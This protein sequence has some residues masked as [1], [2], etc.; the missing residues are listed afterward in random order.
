MKYPYP[1]RQ[2]IGAAIMALAL[3]LP[4]HLA[5]ADSGFWSNPA[6][7]SWTNSA[8]WI[9]NIMAE[10]TDSVA[11]L[12][13]VNLEADR[14]VTLDGART[15]GHLV[16]GDA[17]PDHNWSLE[18]GT[19][20]PLTLTVGSGSPTVTVYNQAATVGVVL[21]GSQGL[22][23]LGNGTLVLTGANTYSGTTLIEA[24]SLTFSDQ[25]ASTGTGGSSLQVGGASGNGVLNLNSSA[26]SAFATGKSSLLMYVGGNAA[27]GNTGAGVINQT[28]GTINLGNVNYLTLGVTGR[29]TYGAYNLA[30][31]TLNLNDGAGFRLGFGGIG[32]FVQSGGNFNCGRWFAIGCGQATGKGVATF[33]GGT[34]TILPTYQM[35]LVDIANSTGVVNLGTEAGGTA[36]VTHLNTTGVSVQKSAGGNGTLNL[37]R[38]TLRLGGPIYRNNSSGGS[39]VLNLNGGTLQAGRD[40]ILLIKSGLSRV[41]VYNG[42]VVF[43]TQGYSSSNSVALTT[44]EGNGIYPAGGTLA[45]GANGGAGYIGA[46]DVTITTSGAG[47]NAMAIATIVGGVVTNVI[48]TCPG[49]NYLPEDTLTFSFIG[50]G[51]SWWSASPYDYTLTAGDL[52]ANSQGGLAKT[53]TGALTLASP[54]TYAGKTVVNDGTLQVTTDGALGTGDVEV[55][56]GAILI[57]E[58]GINSGYIDTSATLM[59][60]SNAA[61]SL[62]FTGTNTIKG[63]SLDGGITLAAL[64]TWGA[65]GA[66]AA[67]SAPQ[68]A[69]QGIFRVRGDA[70]NAALELAAT[71][72]PS[73]LGE[74]VTLTASVTGEAGIPTGTVTFKDGTDVL[75]SAALN[76][77]GIATLATSA[78]AIGTHSLS[79]VFSGN[80]TY[81]PASSAPLTQVVSQDLTWTGEASHFWDSRSLNWHSL[82]APAAYSDGSRV[83]F[84]DSATKNTDIALTTTAF[85]SAV[86]VSNNLRSYSF[87]GP[88]GIAG[89]ASLIKL[90]TG[91]LTLSN[92]NT[93]TGETVIGQG[94]LAVRGEG[95][96]I[97]TTNGSLFVGRD[98]SKGVLEL[99]GSGILNFATTTNSLL[100]YVGGSGGPTD[101]S[102]GAINQTDGILNFGNGNYLT[103]GVT[104]TDS[105]GAYEL[106]GGTLN[107][108]DGAGMRLGFGGIGSFVQSGGNFNCGRWF[109]IGAGGATGKGV[110]TF[111]GGAATIHP[112][113]QMLLPDYANSTGVVNL[114][115][116]AGGTAIVTHLN[117]TGLSVQKSAGGNG[118]LN[119]NRGTLRLGGPIYRNNSS[120]GSAVLNLNGGTLQAGRNNILLI[121]SGLSSVTLYN[122][123]VVFDTQGYTVT[124]SAAL[125][126]A[127]GSGIYPAGG[128]LA[129]G[130]DGGTGY[131][132][133]PDVTVTTS[134]AGSNVMA[135][136]TIANGVVTQVLLTCP[137]ENYV[138]GDMVI[139]MFRGG[140]ADIPANPLYYTLQA[141]DLAG[142]GT[143]GL[144]KVGAGVL[145]LGGENSYAGPTIVSNGTLRVDGS[146]SANAIVKAGAILG[147]NGVISGTVSVEAGGAI[148]AGAGIGTLTLN[149]MPV[150]N[151]AVVAEV[152]RNGGNP[153]ADRLVVSG[154]PATYAG[155]LVLTNRGAPLQVGDTFTL[156]AASEYS[157]NFTIVS[158]TPG[159]EVSW[160]TNN[161]TVN[162]SVSVLTV[163]AT[164]PPGLSYGF[165]STTLDLAWPA[166]YL[167]WGL[168]TNAVSITADA[169]FPYPGSTSQ[170]NI[171]ITVNPGDSNVF[172]RLVS[173]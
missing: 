93:Y 167:G 111:T 116:E 81:N 165:S 108:V 115:T 16:F 160:D 104:A 171:S 99:D 63:L 152:D 158:Q 82:S 25:G 127:E 117:T 40:N 70:D 90:G 59:L 147:G 110:A 21:A 46:P 87:S 41:T 73:Q 53:G 42:G 3:A 35:L 163:A 138:V 149:A 72:S 98:N 169:W 49:E 173:P 145:T 114:G 24:G 52:A 123:G 39:A 7:G 130:A 151:G 55:R 27:A 23:L 4:S 43:D 31:G 101:T 126:K 8:N 57:L 44:A 113:Y 107:I 85:P 92:L 133:A 121:K 56:D 67:H 80:A 78:L 97:G 134:G 37:N 122:G 48:L 86:V 96:S 129:I 29:E 102:A 69:G 124:N 125:A 32:T 153:L 109:A 84:Y 1:N 168:E 71:P 51:A 64:G 88:G 68:F 38:G 135:I 62:N 106:A 131:I 50:G 10:G 141:G 58:G 157:G 132:G 11:D 142:N 83:Q 30:G 91:T 9:G 22:S 100:M 20:G 118:T 95:G 79:A 12:S 45:I 5:Y 140:G 155:T 161:L 156:F 139:F 36:I 2:A 34:A 150:L 18:P 75:G 13:Q 154:S 15:L 172:Y 94:R 166:N 66:G 143:G 6:G 136:A 159:Q 89:S 105:Y 77:A 170:T 26:T 112:T 17:T 128:T 144:T 146:I 162:G 54:S 120:G 76:G 103:L 148:S 74:T 137:G 119:L 19:G 28:D 14:I 164:T 61:V 60:A 65:A 47:S 33:T